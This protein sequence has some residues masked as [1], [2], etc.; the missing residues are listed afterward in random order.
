[1]ERSKNLADILFSCPLTKPTYLDSVG[2][3]LPAEEG[4]EEEDV[5]HHVDQVEQLDHQ[6]LQSHREDF[7]IKKSPI[8]MAKSLNTLP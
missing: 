1:M 7:C 5:A 4:V 8:H 3:E 6:H 2:A